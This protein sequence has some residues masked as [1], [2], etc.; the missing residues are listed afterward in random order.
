MSQQR[1]SI[2]EKDS[3]DY[4]CS[5][6]RI[7]QTMPLK[8]K[9]PICFVCSLVFIWSVI[10]RKPHILYCIIK[11]S[12]NATLSFSSMACTRVSRVPI[13]KILRSFLN[14]NLIG[15]IQL[16]FLRKGLSTAQ[17][18]GY[19]VEKQIRNWGTNPSLWKLKHPWIVIIKSIWLLGI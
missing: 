13:K 6:E 15:L 5:T 11:T 16:S 18:L 3:N 2:M 10:Y 7:L 9:V 12:C 14:Q 8:I 4:I 17:H 19:S 1:V